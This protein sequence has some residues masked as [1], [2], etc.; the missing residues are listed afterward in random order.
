MNV[1]LATANS[2]TIVEI[3]QSTG[4]AEENFV[5]SYAKFKK[6]PPPTIV[7]KRLRDVAVDKSPN[8]FV[9]VTQTGSRTT[10]KKW[11]QKFNETN[12]WSTG[13]KRLQK[14]AV[15]ENSSFNGAFYKRLDLLVVIFI[16][17]GLLFR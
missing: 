14:R 10:D 1:T 6:P 3:I 2:K 7:K 11:V 13:K 8:A 9:N 15:A 16:S 17:C 4:D 5:Y 12:S